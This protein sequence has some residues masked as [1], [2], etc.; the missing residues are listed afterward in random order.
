M[1]LPDFVSIKIQESN[2]PLVDLAKFGFV[3]EPYY[4]RLG[5]TH[6]KAMF[7][8]QGAVEKLLAAQ[9]DLKIYKFK[10]WDG[11]RPRSVQKTIYHKFWDELHWQHPNWSED[12][13]SAE[14]GMYV[15]YPDNPQR[16]PHHSTGGAVDLS[17]VDKSGKELEMG[18]P[19]DHFGP[20]AWQFH[21]EQDNTNEAA[22]NN[23]NLLRNALLAQDFNPYPY[24]WWHF[25]YGDQLWAA[26]RQ[27]PFAIY[28]E[29]Q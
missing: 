15:T 5:L 27:K 29:I 8:R 22:R 21:Y 14:A 16:I 3:L 26:S 20:E 13:I 12:Q 17:L 11:Y 9:K 2:E 24:E 23:R 18:T 10:I 28:G 7:L 6:T 25:D 1:E 4:F 19:F